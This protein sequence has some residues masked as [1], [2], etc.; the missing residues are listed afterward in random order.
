M[1]SD[2]TAKSHI[3]TNAR[4]TRLL[5]SFKIKVDFMV[6]EINLIYFIMQNNMGITVN[7]ETK[8]VTN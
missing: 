7:D 2:L 8:Y 1:Q 4:F 5:Y 6:A 3:M